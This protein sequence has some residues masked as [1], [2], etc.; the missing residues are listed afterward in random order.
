MGGGVALFDFDGDGWLDVFFVNGAALGNPQPQDRDPDKSK[1]EYWN[2]L[3][4]NNLD[5]TFADVTEQAGVKGRGYGM[6]VAAGDYDNDGFPDLFVT[7]YGACILYHNNGDGTF[8]DVTAQSG[9]Q[10]DGWNMSAGFLD[11]DNDGYLDLF[12]TRYLQWN[13]GVGAM[14]CGPNIPGGRA[15]C[16]PNEF[17]AVSNY[18]FHNNHDGTFTDVSEPSR[19]KP[20]T[21]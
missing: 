21:G 12:V 18:L 14:V 15:Y 20:S 7:N 13:F 5:G 17:K 3:F 6:G 2:R 11:Y 10:T 9:I 16:H 4:K 19:I 8:S 1:P